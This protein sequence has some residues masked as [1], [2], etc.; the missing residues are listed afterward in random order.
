M[1]KIQ[2]VLVAALLAAGASTARAQDAQP[3]GQSPRGGRMMAA[4]FANITLSSA[5]Q[6]KIDSIVD[7]YQA[8]RMALMQDGTLDQDARRAKMREIMAKQADEFKAAL[9]PDQQ[10]TFD[11]NLETMRSRMR[12]G[13]GRPPAGR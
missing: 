4:L 12:Q 9:T 5:Q 10:K 11:Q 2:L 7:K 3:Q 6:A 1:K 13:G 8:P